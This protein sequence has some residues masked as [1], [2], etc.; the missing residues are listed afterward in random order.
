MAHRDL[1]YEV[2]RFGRRVG[3]NDLK[4]ELASLRIDRERPARSPWRWPLLL[5]LPV[6]LGLAVLYG[7]RMRQAMAAV[8]VRTVSAAVKKPPLAIAGTPNKTATG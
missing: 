4:G 8:E 3:V 1:E 7:L 6:L 5:L 2:A